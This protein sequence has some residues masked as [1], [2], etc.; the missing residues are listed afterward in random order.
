MDLGQQQ[1]HNNQLVCD[2]SDAHPLTNAVAV[3]EALHMDVSPL[4]ARR[5]LHKHGSHYRIPMCKEKLNE[6]HRQGGLQFTQQYVGW[7]FGRVI[8]SDEKTFYSTTHNRLMCWRRNNFHY[9]PDH[10]VEEARSGHVTAN[11]WGW[12]HLF[13]LGELT[14]MQGRFTADQYLEILVEVMLPSVWAYALPYPERII[15][16]HGR[17]PIHAVRVVTTWFAERRNIEV[18]DWP[19]KGRDMNPIE[20]I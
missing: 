16:M 19:R 6:G 12:L 13:G 7:I 1:L 15:F 2:Y 10:V 20:N 4:T 11:L 3:R 14:D 9:T 17:S 18:L 8:F 5:R